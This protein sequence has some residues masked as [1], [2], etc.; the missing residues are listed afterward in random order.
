MLPCF[1]ALYGD[2]TLSLM[3]AWGC[4]PA[5]GAAQSNALLPLPCFA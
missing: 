2:V 5:A 1:Y 4:F 3:L